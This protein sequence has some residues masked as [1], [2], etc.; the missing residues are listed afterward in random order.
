MFA[1]F[2]SGRRVLVTGHTGFKGGWLSLWLKRLGAAVHGLGLE[3]PTTPNLYDLLRG[4]AFDS[5]TH[6]DIRDLEGLQAALARIQPELVFHLA[7]QPLVRRSYAEPLET[8]TTNAVGTA[9]VL[10]ASRRLKG[11]WSLVIVTTDKCYANREWRHAYRETDALGGHDIYSTSKAA[12]ELVVEGWRRSFFQT[13]GGL[14][15]VATVRAG[16]VIGGGDYAADRLVPDCIRALL[17]GRPIAL[18]NPAAVRPWQ[19][20]LE[21][22]SGY[23]CLGARLHGASP[24]SPWASSFNFGPGPGSDLPVREV[25]REL[26]RFWPGQWEVRSEPNAPHEATHLNLAIDK[27]ASLLGWLPV[28]D[29]PTALRLTV[30]WYRA[31][32]L[33]PVADLV[34]FSLAQIGAYEQAARTRGLAWA[35][36]SRNESA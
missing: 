11:P 17:A 30:E 5:E 12:A 9:H 33:E 13:E 23:L 19:H 20:V 2:Y 8:F 3:A 1:D 25:A 21:C 22:L 31:R 27:A 18:R 35:G 24:D 4:T 10:E 14:G 16:N 29:L 36:A 7:A 6:C 32:H 15:R 34:G 26:V 28:W